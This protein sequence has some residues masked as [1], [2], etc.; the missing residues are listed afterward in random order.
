MI[1]LCTVGLLVN[2]L[3]HAQFMFPVVFVI[4]SCL[5]V[6]GIIACCRVFSGRTGIAR[7]STPRQSGIRQVNN[8]IPDVLSHNRA[9]S[10]L[11]RKSQASPIPTQAPQVWV[12]L[13]CQQA[14]DW[15]SEHLRAMFTETKT[16]C[17]I[18]FFCASYLWC[19]NVS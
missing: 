11:I 4:E 14:P 18:G 7:F 3:T 8:P 13:I 15:S 12:N 17:M 2:K 16:Q 5:V 19:S 6:V 1:L 9:G 10:G